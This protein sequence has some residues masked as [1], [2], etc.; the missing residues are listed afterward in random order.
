MLRQRDAVGFDLDGERRSG[1]L[2]PALESR[3][4]CGPLPTRLVRARPGGVAS[5]AS[6]LHRAGKRLKRRGLV[7]VFS[8]CF[9]DVDAPD[10]VSAPAAVCGDTTCCCFTSCARRADVFLRSLVA[11][12]M[13]GKGRPAYRPRS[14]VGSQS[15][16]R[17]VAD[18][19]RRSEAG[20]PPRPLR[21]GATFNGTA[22]GR[23]SWPII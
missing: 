2:S 4:T 10:Q 7:V 6:V 17:A 19:S 14:V 12:R 20:M 8:D 1:L 9:D 3:I 18:V 15:L 5:L 16:S 11:V 21:P 23:C 13:P 22:L